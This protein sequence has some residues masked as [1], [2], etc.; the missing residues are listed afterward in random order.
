MSRRIGLFI[1]ITLLVTGLGQATT[2]AR[3][4][5]TA[6]GQAPAIDAETTA[7]IKDWKLKAQ[8]ALDVGDVTKARNLYRQILRLDPDDALALRKNEELSAQ[9]AKEGE[10]GRVERLDKEDANARQMRAGEYLAKAQD[11][12]V[13]AKRT[14][15]SEHLERAKQALADA[16]KYVRAGDPSLERL[17]AQIDQE[18]AA[19]RVRLYEIWG[20]VG[21]VVV[22]LIGAAVFYYLR[23]GRVLEMIDGPQIGQQFI[24]QK[25][26]TALG[27]L[28]TEVDWAIEDPLRKISR[29]HCDVIRQGRHYFLV[30]CSMNGTFLNG[31]PLP[32]GQPALLRRGDQIGLG[33]AVTLRF[34]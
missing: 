15:K 2:Y 11:A 5:P 33:G 29:R 9:I 19:R 7:Q 32:K 4:A 22:A 14:G 18:S 25:E 16:R 3:Q 20:L 24:L 30:D 1:V 8:D 31:R 34:R 17:Q 12:L 28:A 13:Q 21:L 10:K 27:A 26:A 6:T 23:S